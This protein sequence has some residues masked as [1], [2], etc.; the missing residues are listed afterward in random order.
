MCCSL[1]SFCGAMPVGFGL[2]PSHVTAPAAT[3]T[4]PILHYTTHILVHIH[5]SPPLH[6]V[7]HLFK[8][9]QPFKYPCL[10]SPSLAV[11]LSQTF[12]A[13]PSTTTIAQLGSCPSTRIRFVCGLWLAIFSL[14]FS[15]LFPSSSLS[16]PSFTPRPV[17]GQTIPSAILLPCMVPAPLPPQK[18]L[19]RVSPIDDFG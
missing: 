11:V 19:L 3:H 2:S 18:T 8:V 9:S 4:C 15:S 5:P 10:P 14:H 12:L 17:L 6:A 13:P 16:L 7:I 1:I